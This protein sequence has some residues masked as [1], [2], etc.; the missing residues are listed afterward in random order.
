MRYRPIR[1][2]R[3]RESLHWSEADLISE[4]LRIRARLHRL[5]IATA[6]LLTE[7]ESEGRADEPIG[8]GLLDASSRRGGTP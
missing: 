1:R 8:A 7:I 4:L 6:L 3:P 5:D 2:D